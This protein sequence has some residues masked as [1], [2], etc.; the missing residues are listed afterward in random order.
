MRFWLPLIAVLSFG[1][2]AQASPLIVNG[3]FSTPNQ[4]GGWSIYTPGTSGWTNSTNDGV[5]IG[6]SPI[7][8]LP[9]ANGGCQNLEVNANTF[10]SD[11]QVI[12]GLT[13]GASYTLSWL[14]GGRT[15]G[16]PDLL[17]VYWGST[18]L[19][20]NSGSVGVWTPNSFLVV[21][22]GTSETLTFTAIAT[23][24]Y[25]SYGN[26]VTNV[27]LTAVPEPSTWAMMI[28]GFFGIGFMA[29]RRKSDLAVRLA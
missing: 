12:T 7:Y 21:A 10:D 17:K 11:Y 4:S 16:G 29:Y 19:T 23:D 2:S 8:G 20:T 22:D 24:G 18:L 14:Y 5:E 28:L 26:E 13:A 25:P 27:M 15:E 6:Y 9:C 1:A 3:D